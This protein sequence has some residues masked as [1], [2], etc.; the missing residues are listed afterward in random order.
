MFVAISEVHSSF[1]ASERLW[2]ILRKTSFFLVLTCWCSI[3]TGSFECRCSYRLWRSWIHHICS[4]P[5]EAELWLW[6]GLRWNCS[7]GCLLYLGMWPTLANK[8]SY[9]MKYNIY[10][11]CLK[12]SQRKNF[13]KKKK[14]KWIFYLSVCFSAWIKVHPVGQGERF[15]YAAIFTALLY[16]HPSCLG[17]CILSSWLLLHSWANGGSGSHLIL[18]RILQVTFTLVSTSTRV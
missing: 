2:L 6:A 12:I 9:T 10:Q 1:L 11:S 4:R 15:A 16:M 7:C 18:P 3:K 5:E 14:L 8:C 13:K 17:N